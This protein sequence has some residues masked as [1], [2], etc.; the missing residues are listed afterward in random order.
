MELFGGSTSSILINAPGVQG[1]AAHELSMAQQGKAGK[2]AIKPS[3][4][5]GTISAIFLLVRGL[6]SKFVL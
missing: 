3:F 5:G 4:T 2:I 1:C 6:S